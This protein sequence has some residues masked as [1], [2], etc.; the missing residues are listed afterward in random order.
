M[1][2]GLCLGTLTILYA[3]KPFFASSSSRSKSGRISGAKEKVERDADR[4]R[5]RGRESINTAML[6]GTL[7]W[8][9]GLSGILY[10]GALAVDPEFGTGFP[11][12]WIFGGLMGMVILGWWLEMRR[13]GGGNG[14][15]EEKEL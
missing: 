13:L 3:W 2:M 14:K 5:E 6:F 4:E 15:T 11:Q 9:T 12:K 10:P 8:I 1:S 7:Y